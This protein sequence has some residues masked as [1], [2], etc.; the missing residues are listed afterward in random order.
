MA[1][2]KKARKRGNMM[3]RQAVKEDS[4]TVDF[5]E[6]KGDG[7]FEC[8]KCGT[9]I[10]PEDESEVTYQIIDTKIVND[11]LAELDVACNTCGSR[12]KVSGFPQAMENL[13]TE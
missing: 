7:S 5:A 12:I 4:F 9:T 1:I 10:S 6:T 11:Q 8:P 3:K 13:P 2:S